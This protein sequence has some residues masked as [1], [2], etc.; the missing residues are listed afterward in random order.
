[1]SEVSRILDPVHRAYQGPGWHGPALPPIRSD[2]TAEVAAQRPIPDAHAIGALVLHVTVWT[3]DPTPRMQG[4]AIPTWL[5]EQDWPAA[6]E[7]A[8]CRWRET[9]DRAQAPREIEA[10]TG[11]L[12]DDR[13]RDMVQG[14][15][16][17]SSYA[18]LHGVAPHDLY[19]AASRLA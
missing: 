6:P 1:M 19:R 15:A 2:V 14:E 17:Y 4:A 10:A 9:L 18:M 12:S 5:P 16:P 3:Q 11:R 13:L 7:A 8:E